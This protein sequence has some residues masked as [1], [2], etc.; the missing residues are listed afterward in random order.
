MDTRRHCRRGGGALSE[1]DGS[2][3]AL[4]SS[5]RAEGEAKEDHRVVLRVR[6]VLARPNYG[7]A[8]PASRDEE[9]LPHPRRDGRR[10]VEFM[11]NSSS[12]ET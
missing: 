1:R 3:D 4:A 11:M 7:R 6:D 2:G 10:R 5:A 9:N 12:D 8:R